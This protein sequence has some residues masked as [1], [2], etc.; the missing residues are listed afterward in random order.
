MN[1][2]WQAAWLDHRGVVNATQRDLQ[3]SIDAV[4]NEGA[5]FIQDLREAGWQVEMVTIRTG[6]ARFR[7]QH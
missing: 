3:A 4:S 5:A 1:A 2:V 6:Q 7:R